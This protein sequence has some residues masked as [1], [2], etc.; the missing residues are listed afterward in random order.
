MSGSPT[1][2]ARAKPFSIGPAADVVSFHDYEG[3]DASFSSEPRTIVQVFEDVRA[4]FEKWEQ[5]APG[6]TYARK[7]DYW[8]TEG[9]FDFIGILS[10]ERRAAWRVQF[11]TRAFAAGIRKVG[12]MDPSVLEQKAVRFYVSTLPNPFPMLPATNEVVVIRGMV[13]AF[14]HPDG[15]DPDAG[16]VWILW[17]VAGTGA[18]Q[19]EVPVKR[20][21]V[22]VISLDGKSHPLTANAGRLRVDLP[23]DSKMPAPVIMVDRPM[24]VAK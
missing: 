8:Q 21:R 20:E 4:V 15:P 11:F 1:F 6:F 3:L 18:A 22:E 17:A 12:I 7:Q 13:A 24:S 19:V 14:R 23:Q 16:Q 5:R 10:S 9:N 2:R